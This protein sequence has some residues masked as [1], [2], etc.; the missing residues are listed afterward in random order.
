MFGR[1]QLASGPPEFGTGCRSGRHTESR[2]CVASSLRPLV[3]GT[4]A[5][6]L[7]GRVPIASA[8][9]DI[10]GAIVAG[11]GRVL[12]LIQFLLGR[13]DR[14]D[15]KSLRERAQAEQVQAWA[16]KRTGDERVVVACNGS[17]RLVR[18]V[19]V[20]LV[21]PDRQ[22]PLDE[23]PSDASSTHRAVL[24]PGD[25][26]EYTIRNLQT[27]APVARPDVVVAFRDFDGS[28]WLRTADDRLIRT[29]T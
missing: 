24:E 20:W 3:R 27:P 18:N 8:T 1:S 29:D 25:D 2:S 7:D 22:A 4:V 13:R 14:N 26:L 15:A 19:R 21:T 12:A 5:G 11:L 17:D 9:T 10:I 16:R 28:E 23:V 6:T